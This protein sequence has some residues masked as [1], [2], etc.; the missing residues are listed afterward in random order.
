MARKITRLSIH[1]G[2]FVNSPA[3]VGARVMLWK[4]AEDEPDDI[5]LEDAKSFSEALAER[6]IRD[7]LSAAMEGLYDNIYALRE[8][9]ESI[10][11]D[12]TVTDKAAAMQAS[13]GQFLEATRQSVPTV[14][15]KRV[16]FD[17]TSTASWESVP[18]TFNAYQAAYLR[19]HGGDKVGGWSDAPSGM[20]SWIAGKFLAGDASAKTFED[21]KFPV[22]APNGKLYAGALRAVMSGRG[23]QASMAP[24]MLE[25]ARSQ[26]RTMLTRHFGTGKTMTKTLETDMAK[27]QDDLA[28]RVVEL[29]EQIGDLTEAND[30]LTKDLAKAAKNEGDAGDQTDAAKLAK[31]LADAKVALEKAN[32]ELAKLK[33]EPEEQ[34]DLKA[35]PASVRRRL[36]DQ[37]N[38]EKRMADLEKVNAKAIED[39]AIEKCITRI[40]KDWPGLPIKADNFG[41]IYRKIEKALD[42]DEMKELQR[43][44]KSHQEFAQIAAS[45]RG[46][47]TQAAESAYAELEAKAEAIRKVDPKLSQEAAIAEAMD[48]FP[49]IYKRYIDEQ[50]VN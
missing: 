48:R 34:I 24:A 43:V 20:K 19:A 26:A 28:E 37:E 3:N 38:L 33:P 36:E 18:K 44:L 41:P 17:G 42:A 11:E 1:E 4:R 2:S 15:A 9:L 21:L 47:S 50:N 23:A 31:E 45:V 16:S 46:T 30:K 6:T 10:L 40:A 12:D 35:L 32:A 49:Q 27:E 39:A 25:R 14:V 5:Q 22:V 13:I 8:S 29:E 7:Q